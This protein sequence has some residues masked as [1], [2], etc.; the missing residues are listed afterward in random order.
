MKEGS[1]KAFIAYLVLS[2]SDQAKYGSLTQNL[3]TQYS[4]N[5]NMYPKDTVILIDVMSNHRH[6]NYKEKSKRI[7]A[8]RRI[9][10]LANLR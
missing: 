9:Q 4:L 8:I 6:D 5:N 3:Q 2:N 7:I 10:I 1:Y